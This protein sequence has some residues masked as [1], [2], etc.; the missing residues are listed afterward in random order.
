MRQGNVDSF[1]KLASMQA[2]IWGVHV[3]AAKHFCARLLWIVLL[4]SSIADVRVKGEHACRLLLGIP[5]VLVII[6]YNLRKTKVLGRLAMLFLPLAQM[7]SF[8]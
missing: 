2:H 6:S 8:D 4:S 3:S 7:F 5:G 1:T